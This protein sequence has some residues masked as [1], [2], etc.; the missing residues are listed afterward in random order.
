MS[1]YTVSN[2]IDAIEEYCN[3]PSKYPAWQL[4]TA[5]NDAYVHY[6]NG[7]KSKQWYEYV[8]LC[9]SEYI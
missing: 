9:L 8:V 1:G 7:L 3:N 4:K 5:I 6:E 2:S